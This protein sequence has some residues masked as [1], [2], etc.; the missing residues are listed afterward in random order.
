MSMS[1]ANTRWSNQR[2]RHSKANRPRS[3][4]LRR[5][6]LADNERRSVA[7]AMG[8]EPMVARARPPGFLGEHRIEPAVSYL[9]FP[10]RRPNEA[11]PPTQGALGAGAVSGR[12]RWRHLCMA[13]RFRPISPS[14][15][16]GDRCGKAL[17][18]AANSR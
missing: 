17:T 6:A 9:L 13:T 10:S 1:E 7:D 2:V 18:D 3:H 11:S 12:R 4:P 15:N 5:S 14:S 16:L 8:Q